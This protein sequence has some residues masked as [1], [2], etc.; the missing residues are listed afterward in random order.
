[1]AP[2]GAPRRDSDVTRSRG[3]LCIGEQ[4]KQDEEIRWRNR[5]RRRMRSLNARPGNP[6]PDASSDGSS[7]ASSDAVP[8]ASCRHDRPVQY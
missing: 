1:M 3:P 2:R 7:D 5:G 6:V 4:E 8:D